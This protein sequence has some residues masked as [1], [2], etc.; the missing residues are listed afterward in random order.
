MRNCRIDAKKKND[1]ITFCL[2]KNLFLVFLKFL[3]LLDRLEFD[4][5][6][7]KDNRV[8]NKKGYEEAQI[9]EKEY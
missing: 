1:G 3:I 4:H 5:D 8:R 2:M 7:N 6:F 9:S